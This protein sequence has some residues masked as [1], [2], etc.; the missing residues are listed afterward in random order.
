MEIDN[1][2]H[3]YV[4]EKRKKEK[5]SGRLAALEALKKSKL[6]GEKNKYEVREEKKTRIVSNSRLNFEFV[7]GTG[8]DKF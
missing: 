8:R 2:P 6:R 5:P 3:V 7:F 1:E 4:R